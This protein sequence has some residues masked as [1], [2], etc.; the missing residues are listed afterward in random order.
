MIRSA[1]MSS[2]W[3]RSALAS[4][5]PSRVMIRSTSSSSRPTISATSLRLRPLS[6]RRHQLLDVAEREAAVADGRANLAERVAALAHPRG[7]PR[8][9]R[10]GGGP[11]AVARAGSRAARP[12]GPAS[13]P[14]RRS[15]ARL[16]RSRSFR[17][18]RWGHVAPSYIERMRAGPEYAARQGGD[19]SLLVPV[20]SAG[21]RPATSAYGATHASRLLLR[22][23]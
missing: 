13:T 22:C 14:R 16:R 12:S 23:A 17:L 21:S 1:S 7:D 3:R 19:G 11:L 4:G 18:A 5:T 9:S 2:S 20:A 10:G 6:L 8:L 15:A